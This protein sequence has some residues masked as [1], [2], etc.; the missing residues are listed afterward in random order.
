MDS[1]ICIGITSVG[2]GIGQSIVDSCRLSRLQLKLV[3]FDVNPLAFG[4]YSCDEQVFVPPITQKDYLN[5][6]VK[7]CLNRNVSLLIPGLDA[8]LPL[9][10]S[11]IEVFSQQGIRVLVAGREFI[12]L[13]RDKV[14][15][16]NELRSLCPTIIPSFTKDDLV[17]AIQKGEVNFPLIAKPKGGSASAGVFIM[18]G[19]DDLSRLVE[20]HVIQPYI[21]PRK[22]DPNFEI[23]RRS[24]GK[25][26]LNQSAEISMQL[27]VS[28]TG[29]ILGRM[30]SYHKLK[31]G[32]PVE[33]SV[34]EDKDLWA[35]LE[36]ALAFL[37][38]N[39]MRGPV[40]FQGRIT[41][42]GMK[43]FE[44]NGRFTGITGLRAL[45]GFNEVEACIRDFLDLPFDDVRLPLTINHRRVGLRQVMN[46]IVDVHY[47]KE[48]T[49]VTKRLAPSYNPTPEKVVL[50]TGATGLL[51]QALVHGLI[52]SKVVK[53][54][55]AAV[56]DVSKARNVFSH[57]SSE[58]LRLVQLSE[59]DN[60][61]L[62]L[63]EVDCLYH[64]AFA[65]PPDGPGAIAK[66]VAFTQHLISE[67]ARYELP[68]FVNISSQSVYGQSHTPPWGEDLSPEPTTTYAMAKWACERM[69]NSLSK[70]SLTTCYT[71]I[72]LARLYGAAHGTRWSELPHL[73]ASRA[74]N[75]HDILIKGGSQ[76]FDLLH[77]RDAVDAL[78]EMMNVHPRLWQPLYNLGS[79]RFTG[80]LEIAEEAVNA[81]D[82]LSNHRHKRQAKVKIETSDAQL[83]MG[84]SIDRFQETFGWQPKISLSTAMDEL[85]KKAVD[86]QL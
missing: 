63:G 45:M 38:S 23:I 46:R 64:L 27:V 65:R 84:M 61:N 40:I 68:A 13:C 37:A 81:A 7:E 35:S 10:A 54:I 47:N 55:I 71:S 33:I 39:G 48:L 79:G 25:A 72:R 20:D 9:I 36:G 56:R 12:R 43:F 78:V 67:A 8:E 70:L 77:I 26:Q 32:V 60:L 28:K 59:D 83:Q 51:G 34:I 29:E 17:V 57:V 19:P 3:G 62:N 18:N 44:M 58:K 2:S 82:R 41:S 53:Q 21:F 5:V 85:V 80:I 74:A 30:A 69:V 14:S 1:T 73:F 24:V 86:S 31:G 52:R 66:S 75:G 76:T 42:E 6:L 16:S 49:A 4:A 15:W 50:I 22:D 11:N